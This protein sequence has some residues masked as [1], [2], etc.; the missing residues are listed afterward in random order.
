MKRGS[1]KMN[2]IQ[3]HPS[4]QEQVYQLWN[5]AAVRQGFAPLGPE[6]FATLMIHHPYF[7]AQYAFLLMKEEMVYGFTCGCEGEDLPKGKERGYFTCLLL[8]P[9]METAMN[10]KALLN[11]LEGAFSKAGKTTVVCNFFNPMRLP[12]IIPNTNNCQHNNAPGIAL[13]VLLYQW[14]KEYGYQD[15]ARECAMYLDMDEFTLPDEIQEKEKAAASEGY[16][17]EWYDERIHKELVTMVD[18][19]NNTMWSQEIPYA[20][21]HINMIVAVKDHCVTGFTGPVYPE[22]TG[23]GYFAGIAVAKAHE[24]HGLGTLLFYRL[25]QEEKVAGARY[26]SLFTGEDNPAQNIYKQAGFVVKRIFA[27]MIKEIV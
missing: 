8:H 21:K 10:A 14:M 25:C 24:R 20:A 12:W 17:I 11:A 18:S 4:Y 9:D 1:M 2:V 6:E 26:M 16:T 27:V 3:Y 5:L 15:R 23:R 19:M 13:D 7:S 22:K